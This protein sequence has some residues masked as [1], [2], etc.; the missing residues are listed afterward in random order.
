MAAFVINEW[1]WH[2]SLGQNGPDAQRQAFEVICK[3]ANSDH[4]VVVIEGSR[5]DQKAWDL[6]KSSNT[7]VVGLSKIFFGRIRVSPNRCI[8]LKPDMAADLS[9][10][11]GSSVNPD[12]Q[13][14]VRAQLSVPG[15]LLVTTDRP[16]RDAVGKA[17][18]PCL[19]REEFLATY[20][21]R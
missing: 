20:C 2:D 16:L 8:L 14:L 7:V 6:W 9:D 3:L 5:F 11:L 21:G 10:E 17:G 15:S 4:Q 19:P 13:Y 1:L 18:L 12:D